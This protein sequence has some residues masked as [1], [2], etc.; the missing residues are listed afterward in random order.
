M[1]ER[2]GLVSILMCVCFGIIE[3]VHNKREGKGRTYGITTRRDDLY[4]ATL[5][6]ARVRDGAVPCPLS[7][8]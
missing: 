6:V 5:G 8:G 1:R 7:Y 3:W 2:E 4:V